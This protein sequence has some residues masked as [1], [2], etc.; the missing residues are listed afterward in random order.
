MWV[1]SKATAAARGSPVGSPS[2]SI[3]RA[4]AAVEAVGGERLVDE[5]GVGAVEDG[6]VGQHGGGGDVGQRRVAGQELVGGQQRR[7]GPGRARLVAVV[8]ARRSPRPSR[9]SASS[10]AL[11]DVEDGAGVDLAVGVDLVDEVVGVDVVGVDAAQALDRLGPGEQAPGVAGAVLEGH[12][13]GEQVA[14]ALVVGAA[15]AALSRAGPGP[16]RRA[17]RGR[18]RGR[19]RWRPRPR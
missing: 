16:G 10:S 13:E 1:I 14:E 7:S 19:C 8:G 9:P 18:T 15:L 12:E 17:R 6:L 4:A 3:D 2:G 11:E 5:L